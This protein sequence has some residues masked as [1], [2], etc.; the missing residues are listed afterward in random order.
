MQDTIRHKHLE[1]RAVAASALPLYDRTQ[2]AAQELCDALKDSAEEVRV[3]AANALGKLVGVDDSTVIHDLTD[4]LK[5]D[6]RLVVFN[7]AH[8]LVNFGQAADTA[9]KALLKRLRH[10]LVDCRDGDAQSLLLAIDA[11]CPDT[12][13]LIRDFFVDADAEYRDLALELLADLS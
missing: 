9:S 13:T 12:P 6:S 1:V 11:I 7:A 2:H 3:A 8:S 4:A 10:A 5:D